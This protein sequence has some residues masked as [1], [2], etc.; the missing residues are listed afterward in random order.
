MWLILEVLVS[1]DHDTALGDVK[2]EL[3]VGDVSWR[4]TLGDAVTHDF[5][6]WSSF[7]S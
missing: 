2:S 4:S 3:T 6:F 5:A 1:E 7:E